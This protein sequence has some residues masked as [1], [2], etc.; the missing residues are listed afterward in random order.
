MIVVLV[1]V[2][3]LVLPR[4]MARPAFFAIQPLLLPCILTRSMTFRAFVTIGL[5]CTDT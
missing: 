3:D 4:K 5:S 2:L 1:L